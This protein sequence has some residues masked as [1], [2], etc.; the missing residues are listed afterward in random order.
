MRHWAG[1]DTGTR[2]EGLQRPQGAQ[3][4]SCSELPRFPAGSV[5]LT[6]LDEAVRSNLKYEAGTGSL[7]RFSE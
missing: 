3:L 2:Q 4:P 5:T 1:G 7:T 6:L